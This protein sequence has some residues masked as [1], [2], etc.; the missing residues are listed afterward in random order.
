LD[1]VYASARLRRQDAAQLR[2]IVPAGCGLV[3]VHTRYRHVTVVT[4]RADRVT[5][6]AQATLPASRLLCSGRPAGQAPAG[7]PTQLRIVLRRVDGRYL[8]AA[9]RR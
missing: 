4:R 2:A 9:L 8:I 3:G 7:A 1:R 5:L 6:R